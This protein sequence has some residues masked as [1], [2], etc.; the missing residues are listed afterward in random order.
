M[1]RVRWNLADDLAEEKTR[2]TDAISQ[3]KTPSFAWKMD[4]VFVSLFKEAFWSEEIHDD[5]L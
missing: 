5:C 2:L 3:Q 4:D 1:L